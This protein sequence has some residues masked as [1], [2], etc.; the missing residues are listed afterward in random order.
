MK[1]RYHVFTRFK[2]MY[3]LLQEMHPSFKKYI[4]TTVYIHITIIM[5]LLIDKFFLY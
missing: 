1:S 3:T 4:Y 2:Q 5:N